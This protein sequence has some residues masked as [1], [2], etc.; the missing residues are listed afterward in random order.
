MNLIKL[1][2]VVETEK[3]IARKIHDELAN[4]VYCTM[5]N[6]RSGES[7]SKEVLQSLENIYSKARRISHDLSLIPEESGLLELL[8]NLTRNY[9]TDKLKIDIST[10]GLS[11]NEK[12]SDVFKV[13]IYRVLQ[14][15]LSNIVKHANASNVLI[16]LIE[17][18]GK[19]NILVEDNGIG[20]D[21]SDSA[22]KGLGLKNAEIRIR[23]IGGEIN[24]DSTENDGTTVLIEIPL[25]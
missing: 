8:I 2:E 22:N 20:F 13:T 23:S 16:E 11:S 9:E 5:L 3:R 24:F 19:L 21:I 7:P 14:E 6:V 4:D 10:N 15:L 1:K 12:F 18:N 17:R 25:K